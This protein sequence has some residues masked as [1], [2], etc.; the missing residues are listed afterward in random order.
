MRN[1][2]AD[3]TEHLERYRAVTLQHFD[4]LSDDELSW[5]PRPDA[6]SCGQHLVHIRQCE[7]FYARGLFED[8]WNLDRLRLP[9]QSPPGSELREQFIT[10]RAATLHHLSRLTDDGLNTP[11][12]PPHASIEASLRS[13][14]WFILEHEIHHKAQ[15]SE[16][17]RQMGHVPPFF[18]IALPLGERPDIQARAELGGF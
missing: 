4:I 1:E 2:V 5:R 15:L 17:L 12:R 18:A 13:W 6:Y 14:L 11:V 3:I 16:Y 7:D 8:D 9:N 10:V